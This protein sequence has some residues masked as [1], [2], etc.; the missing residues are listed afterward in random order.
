[1]SSLTPEQWRALGP[2]LDQALT[3]SGEERDRWL[4]LLRNEN[5]VLAGQIQEMLE[6]DQAAEHEGILDNT[7]IRWTETAG[8]A[9]QTVGAYCLVS[10]IGHGGM[11]T[12]WLAERNDGRFQRKAAVKFLSAALVGHGAEERFKREG[13]ILARLTNANIAELLDAGVTAGGQPYLILEYVEGEPIDGYCDERKLDVRSRI[14]LFRDV[15]SAVAHAHSNLIV[16]RDIKPSNVLVNKD[17]QVKLLDFGIAKL[18]EGEGQ[19]GRAT[20]LT[21]EG[22]SALTP[23]YAAPEQLMGGLVTTA[24]DIYALGVL[25]YVLLTGEHPA[26]SGPH[27]PAGLLK[28]I[29]ETE[30]RRPSEVVNSDQPHADNRGTIAEKLRRQLRG[31]VDT[32]VLKALKKNPQ[33]RYASV[34]AMADDLTRYLRNEP[35]SARPDTIAY[36]AAKFVRRNRTAVALASIAA[37]A[38]VGGLVGTLMQ[39]RTARIQRD[40]AL[41]QLARAERMI[42]LNQLLLSEVAGQGKPLTVNQLLG[43]A[44]RIAEREPA[45]Q[46]PANHIELLIAVGSQYAQ[47]DDNRQGLHLLEEAYKLSRELGEPSTRARA[48]CSLS[49]AIARNGD[50]ARAESL[51]QEGL[52]AVPSGPRFGPTRALCLMLAV[53]T[54]TDRGATKLAIARAEA[55]EKELQDS[56]AQSAGVELDLLT[57][58][59][60]SY[61]ADGRFRESFATFER[62]GALLR[63]LGY[64]ETQKAAELFHAWGVTL[65]RAGQPLEAEKL[66]RRAID[67]SRTSQREEAVLPAVLYEYA[68]ALREIRRFPE[69]QS[70]AERVL[71]KAQEVDNQIIIAQSTLLLGRIYADEGDFARANTKFSEVE[72]RMRKLLPPGHYAFAALAAD[73]AAVAQ[74]QGNLAKAAQLADEAVAIGEAAIKAGQEGGVW[75]PTFLSRRSAIQL[76]AGHAEQAVTDASRALSLLRSVSETGT[77]SQR[78]GHAFLAL[79]RALQAQGKSD[80]ALAA[81]RSA[82]QQLE[83]TLGPDHPDCRAAQQL[84]QSAPAK[85]TPTGSQTK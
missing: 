58:L 25:F 19:E 50:L 9:G 5:P 64:D 38:V 34:T 59:A 8:L 73:K 74:G 24:T 52:Q 31:D 11:G 12:V 55:A 22:G 75:L 68:G 16:H 61:G 57:Q 77:S 33:E 71:A 6:R 47:I 63:S 45:G 4:Q 62:A 84:A 80:E 29:T 49:S 37:V 67:I 72:P 56:P 48:A 44:E 27:S 43:R 10:T 65:V 78:L 7:P 20:L 70:Y 13:A 79:G 69:A 15:A 39:A 3:L 41:G 60:G 14:R 76:E 23:E 53:N 35:I 28:A 30:P 46:D 17:G 51:V 83:P 36:R 42:D 32:I 1:M 26:G 21:R 2:Y 81:F 82:V 85:E 18:L 54:A 40:F 66:Y